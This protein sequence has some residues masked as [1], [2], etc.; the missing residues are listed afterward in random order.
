MIRGKRHPFVGMSFFYTVFFFME[1]CKLEHMRITIIW[2]TVFVLLSVTVTTF[3]ADLPSA[4]RTTE[5][6]VPIAVESP[7]EPVSG[8]TVEPGLI[9]PV[10]AG[11]DES[12]LDEDEL[13]KPD[14]RPLPD[15]PAP[16]IRESSDFFGLM[17][18][19]A[20]ALGVTVALIVA[21]GWFLKGKIK[22]SVS[23]RM[24]VLDQFSFAPGKQVYL[25]Q[26]YGRL[27]VVG[28]S[29]DRMVRLAEIT[30]PDEKKEILLDVSHGIT[31][32]R[33]DEVLDDLENG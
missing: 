32:K 15:Y 18:R 25:L 5:V 19:M 9:Y 30:D 21:I 12:L 3:A 14:T 24:Q 7:I 23:R 20:F 13:M 8:E 27:L 29:G 28:S 2:F 26:V 11:T 31:G 33:F 1:C 16:P 4:N 17:L 6:I 10:Q 22:G